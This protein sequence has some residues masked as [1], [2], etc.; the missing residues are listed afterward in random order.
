[1]IV[2]ITKVILG[3]KSH[4]G[5]CPTQIKCGLYKKNINFY[6]RMMTP[7]RGVVVMSIVLDKMGNTLGKGLQWIVRLLQ[8]I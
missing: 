3:E 1:M 8:H 7:G 6:P 4:H 2:K 5:N